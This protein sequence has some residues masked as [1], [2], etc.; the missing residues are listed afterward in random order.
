MT[1][2]L[3]LVGKISHS[4]WFGD[5]RLRRGVLLVLLAICAVLT[6]FPERYRAAV[7]LTPS[8]PNSLGLSGTLLQLGA[9]SSV[10]GGQAAIDVSV[11]MGRSL[12]VRS[13]VSDEMKLP[14]LLG[15][16]KLQTV[17][18]LERKV[19][20]RTLRGGII[21]IEMRDSDPAFARKVVGRYAEAIRGQLGQIARGQTTYKRRILEDL[22]TQ[23]SD[24]LA[25]AQ[26]AYD[27]FRRQSRYGDPE[28]AVAQVSGRVPSLERQILDKERELATFR[29]FATNENLQVQRSIAELAALRSQL[30]E[31]QS[32]QQTRS[33]SLAQVI[34]QSTQTQR[35][36][37]ELQIARELYYSYQ[38]FLQGTIV[39]DLTS[40]AN[41]RILEPA[42]VDPDRQINFVP[43][44]LGLVLLLLGLAVEFYR[45][46][47]A[48]GDEALA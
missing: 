13:K 9:G 21:E 46:R 22:V 25:N 47:P 15:M 33:G 5:N 31:A 14:E 44:V 48:V 17:R 42:Y 4:R 6:F 26:A 20:I 7:T 10:F 38:R 28:A 37:R 27:S 16:T 1:P 12:F 32:Q 29:Q 39:E 43:L 45:F 19:K 36:E 8:D 30:A 24:R 35:L 40:T 11:K 18:W 2:R 3:S 41:I 23:A 34:T